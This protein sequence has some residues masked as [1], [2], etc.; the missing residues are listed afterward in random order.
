MSAQCTRCRPVNERCGAVVST[1]MRG[2]SGPGEVQLKAIHTY[3]VY[4]RS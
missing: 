4:S 1:R 3:S 2:S